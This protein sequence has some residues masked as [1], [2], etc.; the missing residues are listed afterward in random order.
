M[1]KNLNVWSWWQKYRLSYNI[2]SRK[3]IW[4]IWCS[5]FVEVSLK[6]NVY[7]FLVDYTTIDKYYMLNNYKYSM[8]KDIKNNVWI[9]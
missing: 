3:Y 9:Y 8:V 4:N 7:D 5:E 2:L 1:E 6:E